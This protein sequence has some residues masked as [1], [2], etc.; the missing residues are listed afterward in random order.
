MFG[1][2]G[3]IIQTQQSIDL[4]YLPMAE[5]SSTT[6]YCISKTSCQLYGGYMVYTQYLVFNISSRC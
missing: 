3:V 4:L 2:D 5:N 6:L 1:I